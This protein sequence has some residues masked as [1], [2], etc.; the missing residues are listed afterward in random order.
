MQICFTLICFYI[1][2]IFGSP[3][4]IKPIYQPCI[5]VILFCGSLKIVVQQLEISYKYNA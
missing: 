1:M 5:I 4:E 2:C 3:T